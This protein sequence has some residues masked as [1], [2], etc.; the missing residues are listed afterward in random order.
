MRDWDV[1]DL[2]AAGV[3]DEHEA[4]APVLVS[5]ATRDI[6]LDPVFA[7]R[8]DALL[9]TVPV[10]DLSER[11]QRADSGL[12]GF[13]IRALV[14]AAFDAVIARQG[15]PDR[16]TPE[17]VLTL[18]A[19]IAAVQNP[20]AGLAAWDAAAEHVLDGLTNR[21]ERER[22][23]TVSAIVYGE[24]S[25]GGLTATPVP[26]RFWLLREAEDQHTG[27]TYLE[28]SV[29][30]VN[31]LVGGLD[32]PIEDA[33]TALET[34]LERQLARGELDAANLTAVRARR[35][36]AG[37]LIQIE[38]LLAET[39][40]Y[41]PGTDWAIEAPKLIADALTHL[42]ECLT[43]EGRLLEHVAHGRAEATG[44]DDAAERRAK[45]SAALTKLLDESLH[46]HTALLG[47][48]IG[49]RG[50]FLDAQDQQMFRPSATTIEFDLRADLLEP[51]LALH[52]TDAEHVAEAF[53]TGVTGPVAPVALNW[54][55]FVEAL[56][57]PR[58]EARVSEPEVE[59]DALEFRADPEPLVSEAVLEA[60]HAVLATV[61]LPARLSTLIAACPPG[62]RA[63]AAC[64]DLIVAATLRS[65]DNSSRDGHPTETA[66]ANRGRWSLD[67]DPAAS[68]SAP[69]PTV[70]SG[71]GAGGGRGVR[72]LDVL[73]PDAACI[74]D[75]RM[76]EGGT[77]TGD[78]LIVCVDHDQADA[79]RLGDIAT[80]L[81]TA[82]PDSA[83]DPSTDGQDCD[84]AE[85]D[86][87]DSA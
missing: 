9:R 6:V 23:F 43:R 25:E 57:H 26:R 55:D 45:I 56:I 33:Q 52:V 67:G 66:G 80:P 44:T 34:V 15:F 29:D 86:E 51:T 48:L 39:E 85:L 1:A 62:D 84:G 46:L 77:W 68:A 64:S 83:D 3:A 41:L 16:A 42:G 2:F 4:S 24:T 20:A 8:R 19:G 81:P 47:R 75:G 5:L 7:R 50:R 69:G 58:E 12:A 76:L 54:G 63:G 10:H 73:G 37:Y 79:V 59:K 61:P 17:D 65:F 49:A 21:R 87:R 14:L 78:D 82:L 71:G 30:A 70:A 60:T 40:R 38:E 31:A 72:L 53:L 35:L 32:I 27:T 18:L 22:Q 11:A 13:D 74:S 36:T 28:A